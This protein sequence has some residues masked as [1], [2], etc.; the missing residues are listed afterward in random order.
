[1]SNE[2]PSALKTIRSRNFKW[3]FSFEGICRNF[4]SNVSVWYCR[5]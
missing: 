1:V 5:I 3:T 4:N 2:Y